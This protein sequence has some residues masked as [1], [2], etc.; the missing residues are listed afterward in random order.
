MNMRKQKE[1]RILMHAFVW[2]NI[3]S[4]KV[5]SRTVSWMFMKLSTN[6]DQIPMFF[7]TCLCSLAIL[8]TKMDVLIFFLI[9]F[10]FSATA[11][12]MLTTLEKKQV[13]MIL[14]QVCVS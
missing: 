9:G 10:D 4:L 7:Y 13:L 2:E 1:E 8:W 3:F 6:E 5:C 11:A 12:W 14:Y